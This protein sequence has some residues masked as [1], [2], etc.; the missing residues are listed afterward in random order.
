MQS[1]VLNS[2][3]VRAKAATYVGGGIIAQSSRPGSH[4]L[5]WSE[6][7]WRYLDSYFGGTDFIGQETL[8][9][10]EGPV[11]AMNYYGYIRHPELIDAERAGATI[12]AALS[13]LY[14]QGRFLGGFEWTGEYGTY[15]DRSEGDVTHFRGR[16]VICVDNREAYAL[17]YF[18]GLIKA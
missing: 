14:R 10:H 16:E 12:K 6:R 13:T 3:I 4:D 17:D 8:W 5:L 7:P 1:E 2:V 18:G 9:H 15:I 11:W